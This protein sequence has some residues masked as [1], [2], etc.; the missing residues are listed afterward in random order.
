M[1]SCPFE[2]IFEQEQFIKGTVESCSDGFQGAEK[3]YLF[4]IGGILLE[5]I[6]KKENNLEGLGIS[7]SFR[8]NSIAR[9]SNRVRFDCTLMYSSWF[10][11]SSLAYRL[12]KIN[13]SRLKN[14]KT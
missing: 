6:K 13:V 5:P 4:V 1:H 2:S 3:C 12:R 8:R 7:I 10:W 14:Q 9:G 11:H